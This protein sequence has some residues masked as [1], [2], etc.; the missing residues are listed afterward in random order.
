MSVDLIDPLLLAT[1]VGGGDSPLFSSLGGFVEE[2]LAHAYA[3]QVHLSPE[4]V[5]C[6][7]WWRHE[8]AVSRLQALWTAYEDLAVS[9]PL[10]MS[11]W[12]S[13]HA[14]L[15]MPVLLS[16]AGAFKYCSAGGGHKDTLKPLRTDREGAEPFLFA[17][18]DSATA[19][20]RF[21]SVGVFVEE[22]LA[23]AYA[24]QVTDSEQSTWCP[25]WWRH[26]EAV[27]RLW[28]LW[29]AFESLRMAG[30]L[31]MSEWWSGHADLIMPSLFAWN[32]PFKY[33][34]VRKGH[35][36]MLDPLPTDRADAPTHLFAT[37]ASAVAVA[38]A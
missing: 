5:W 19:K 25:Q 9:G 22:F 12:W 23:H 10:G 38:V 26:V 20:S 17:A 32:G 28:A 36:D 24:R 2:F 30:P 6:S 3:R 11:E 15:L 35:K 7:Q 13:G 4:N 27:D 33:C 1:D 29:R 31:G 16:P 14:D 8:E 18:G 34:G 37:R 21:S